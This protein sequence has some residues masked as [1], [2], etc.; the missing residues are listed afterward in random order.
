MRDDK[1]KATKLRREGKSYREIK[2]ELGVPVATLSDW[3]RDQDWSKTLSAEL[4]QKALTKNKARIVHLGKIRGENL[5]RLYN[6]ARKEAEEEFQLLK[7]HPLFVAGVMIYWGE[8]DKAS[9]SGFRVTNIDPEMIRIFISFLQKVCRAPKE[10]IR[11]SIIIYPDL[12]QDVCEKYWAKSIGLPKESFTKT[13]KI[14]GK[15]TTKRLQYGVCTVNFSSRF[16][17][18]K[19]LVWIDLFGK[20]F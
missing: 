13:I 4:G 17:K 9:K 15:H 2:A 1:E 11:A 18:E 5:S 14:K 16:L 6:E 7:N 10:R 19:M 8:G 3:F 20:E 12:N